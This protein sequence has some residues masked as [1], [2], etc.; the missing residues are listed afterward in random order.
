MDNPACLDPL[1]LSPGLTHAFDEVCPDDSYW[2]ADAPHESTSTSFS[3]SAGEP[4]E[5][6]VQGLE[7]GASIF[8][9]ALRERGH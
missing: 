2:D 8:S 5:Q 4:L 9:L 1:P 6:R 7:Q 3:P